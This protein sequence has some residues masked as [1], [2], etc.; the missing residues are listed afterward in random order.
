ML[1]S[2]GAILDGAPAGPAPQPVRRGSH[3]AG[4]CEGQFWKPI[5]R[6]ELQR[7][8]LAAHRYELAGRRAGRRNGPLGHIGLEILELL[9]NLVSYRTGRLEPSVAFLMQKLRRSKSA[10]Y[11]ALN[12][13]RTHGFL[14][15][16]RRYEPTGR[17]GRG[18][19]LRQTSNAYRLSLPARALRL[20]G[21]LMQAPPLP[22]DVHHARELQASEMAARRASLALDEL[23][24][25]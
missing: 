2:I 3:R 8:R 4:R 20:L 19:Q 17:E 24:L 5:S 9:A 14:D 12:A 11:D 6:Q 25:F 1:T 22:D 23:P 13:L 18:P 21:R 7:I 15:W 10:I 16:R